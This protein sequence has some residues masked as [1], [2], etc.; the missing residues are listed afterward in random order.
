MTRTFKVTFLRELK[1]EVE[2]TAS[3]ID[4]A[5]SEFYSKDFFNA[6]L[7]LDSEPVDELVCVEEHKELAAASM[8]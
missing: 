5:L 4:E 1:Y 8:H 6:K 3:T 2:I 7:A